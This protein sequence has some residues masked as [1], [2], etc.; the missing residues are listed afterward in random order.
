MNDKVLNIVSNI[1]SYEVLGSPFVV[2]ALM[3]EAGR[4]IK[5]YVENGDNPRA[6]INAKAYALVGEN[7]KQQLEKYLEENK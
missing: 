5:Y 6:V 1:V 4:A 7:V 3:K 2:N